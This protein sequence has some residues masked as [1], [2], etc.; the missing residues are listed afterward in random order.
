MADRTELLEAALDSFP[1]GVAVFDAQ[2]E[3]ILWN[4]SAQGITGYPA[5][6]LLTQ[7]IPEGL[8]LLFCEG[9][10]VWSPA[11]TRQNL[12]DTEPWF[13]RGTSWATACP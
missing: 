10:Q 7:P 9:N 1:D 2:G 5:I 4:Q 6:E 12:R 8:E 11:Q 13:T 3:V